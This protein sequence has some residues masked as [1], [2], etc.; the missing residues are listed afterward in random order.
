MPA[1]KWNDTSIRYNQENRTIEKFLKDLRSSK[2][3]NFYLESCNVCASACAVDSVLGGWL[4]KLPKFANKEFMTQADV[5][6]NYIYSFPEG[7]PVLDNG[8][9]LCENE[10]IENLAFAINK[11]STCTAKCFYNTNNQ[12]IIEIIKQ[13]LNN[14]NAIVTSYTD[15]KTPGHYICIVNYDTT[16]KSFIY[17]DSWN[18]NSRN[19]NCGKM[20]SFDESDLTKCIKHRYMVVSN[21]R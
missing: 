14:G 21:K 4:V 7:L 1:I 2:Q 6:F 20:E 3:V 12:E 11:L 18:N 5:M 9:G 13:E 10:C 15:E 8:A 17:Y 19:K 16:N